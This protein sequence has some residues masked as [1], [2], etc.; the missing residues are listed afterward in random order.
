MVN[1]FNMSEEQ[2]KAE[3][4]EKFKDLV[5]TIEK[6]SVLDLSELVKV[7]EDTFGVTAAAPVMMGAIPVAGGAVAGAAQETPTTVNVEL[8]S[9]GENKV[10]VI[11]A[12]RTITGLGLAEA[13]AKVESAPTMLKEGLS[14]E[15]A[16]TLKK[17]LTD[18]GA[19]VT[20]K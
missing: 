16:E 17:Q 10:N 7:L 13:K 15:E 6:M 1:I 9:F 19:T 14:K 18:A 3:V 5:A 12:V 4:P 2:K 11:K 8:T 20:L